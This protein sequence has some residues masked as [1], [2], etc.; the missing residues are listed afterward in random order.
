MGGHGR[1]FAPVARMTV[2]LA[3]FSLTGCGGDRATT[4]RA[5]SA[6]ACPVTHAGG[7]RPP[8]KALQNF[9]S[10]V[11]R[12][13]DPGWWGNGVLWTHLPPPT[14]TVRDPHTGLIDMKFP[15]FRARPGQVVVR[16]QRLGADGAEFAADTGTPAEYGAT[17]FTPSILSFG[18]PGCWRLTA[19]LA[20]R[21]LR[22][23]I[24]VSAG[25]RRT[26]A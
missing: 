16:A 5:R 12:P 10:P 3:A 6:L 18:A 23:T 1:C 14:T 26:A 25:R 17:G 20:H 7:P 9:G 15:W 8:Q 2:A 21:A 4:H 24:L 13:T 22:V 19:H 11:G